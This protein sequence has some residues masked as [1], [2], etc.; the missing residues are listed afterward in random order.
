MRQKW[1]FDSDALARFHHFIDII[2]PS[3]EEIPMA[4]YLRERWQSSGIISKTDV[5]GNIYGSIGK[6]NALNLG[7]IAHMDTVAVQIT[8]ILPN[9]YLQLRHIGLRPHTLLGQPMIVVTSKG[10]INGLIGF[11]PTSQYG[12]PKGLVDEDLWMDIGAKNYEDACS[13]IQVGDLAV[14]TPRFCELGDGFISGTAIDDRV[15]LFIMDECLNWFVNHPTNVNLHF[16]GSVQEEVGLRG[17]TIIASNVKLDACIVL[18]VDYA[19]DTLTPHENQ[20]GTLYLGKGVGIHVKSDINPVLRRYAIDIAK[21][22][23]I[24]HQISLGR[25]IYGGTDSTALQIQQNGIATMNLNIPCRYMHSPIEMCHKHDI[26]CCVQLLISVIEEFSR[27]K[28][29]SFIPGID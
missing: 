2:S 21:E 17:S 16:I 18:D 1:V 14:L 29:N 4:K 25:Y 12:Q 3:T 9:G 20:M 5:M 24:D 27:N 15:G 22:F 23:G 8:K 19:T 6:G 11:D 13:M 28:K 10:T 26:E 7:I